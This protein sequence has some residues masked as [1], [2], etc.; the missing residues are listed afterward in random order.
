MDPLKDAFRKV[1]E[2]FLRLSYEVE[3]LKKEV[4]SLNSALLELCKVLRK[5]DKK[6]S[7]LEDSHLLNRFSSEKTTK[8]S[9]STHFEQDS[10]HPAHFSTH[11]SP[12]KP[13]GDKILRIST[14]NKGV[15]TD[16]QTL[17]QTDRHSFP[18]ENLL[19][20]FS[21]NSLENTSKLVNS[22]ETLKKAFMKQFKSFTDQEMAVFLTMYQLD[23][24]KGSS[25]YKDIAQKLGL[26][27]SS[28]RDYV[29]RLLEKKA[30][31]L[32]KRVNNK[33]IKFTLLPEFKKLV[34]PSTLLKLRDL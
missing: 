12:F 29:K 6:V 24:E 11:L 13:L 31:I 16:R 9:F 3:V 27:E 10:T 22:L 1:K 30:P 32:K 23:E 28:I 20:N 26:T 34:S 19:E 33:L 15:S 17:R 21:E 5:L 2:D 7:V 14:G 4:S 25:T 18:S 8:Q